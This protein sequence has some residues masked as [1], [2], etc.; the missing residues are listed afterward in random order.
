MKPLYKYHESLI[1][2]DPIHFLG[3]LEWFNIARCARE[4]MAEATHQGDVTMWQRHR[5]TFYVALNK[6]VLYPTNLILCDG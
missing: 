3:N 2:Y 1:E 5:K 6:M 4:R